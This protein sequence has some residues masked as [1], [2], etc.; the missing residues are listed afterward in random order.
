MKI[1]VNDIAASSGGAMSILKDFYNYI[2]DNDFENEWIFLLGDSYLEETN[3][4]Q[5]KILSDVKQNHWK[6][7]LF[8]F[9]TGK[10]YIQ[11][12]QPD[13]VFSLQNIITFGLKVPQVVYIHQ[14]LP[15]QDVKNFSFFKSEEQS[16]ALYQ[17]IIGRIIIKS[18]QKAN[19]VIVQTKWMKK[20]VCK[21]ADIP[22]QK[23]INILPNI[24]D[25]SKYKKLN[26]LQPNQF[27]YPTADSIYKNNECIY[28][29]SVILK[30]RGYRDFNVKL[31][32]NTDVKMENIEFIGRISRE[33]V[34]EEYNNSILIFPSYIETF[35]YPMAEAMQMG[36][37][38][39]ASDCEFSREILGEYKNAYFFNPFKANELAELMLKVMQGDIKKMK[40]ENTCREESSWGG[41]VSVL[42]ELI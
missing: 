23:V 1:V 26:Q 13:V 40:V 5:V 19:K 38:V 31:T 14:S 12:L 28:K 36:T 30:Q 8:D 3:H 10:K 25:L 9:S 39:L 17:H 15:F 37:I 24:E 4:I 18:A 35:G 42:K 27:F 7:L 6:K 34:M 29:A 2:K 41:V 16:F 32:I 21:K 20:A 22:Y 11:R 33:Q